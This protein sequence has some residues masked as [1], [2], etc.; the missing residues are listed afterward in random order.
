MGEGGRG[1]ERMT[2]ARRTVIPHLKYSSMSLIGGRCRMYSDHGV[3]NY[4]NCVDWTKKEVCYLLYNLSG[5]FITDANDD[6][7][8]IFSF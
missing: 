1:D 8:M 5:I 4:M 3:I 6:V 7:G 2:L